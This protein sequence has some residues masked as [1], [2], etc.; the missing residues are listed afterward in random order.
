LNFLQTTQFQLSPFKLCSIFVFEKETINLKTA[1]QYS[2]YPIT[3]TT[4]K[5]SAIIYSHIQSIITTSNM[6]LYVYM[7][8]KTSNL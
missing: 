5:Q 3:F 1:I 2:H 8:I 7:Y 6:Q 4:T